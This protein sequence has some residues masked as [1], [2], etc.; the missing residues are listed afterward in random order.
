MNNKLKNVLDQVKEND[1]FIKLMEVT[2]TMKDNAEDLIRDLIQ[3]FKKNE[4]AEVDQISD[5][6]SE[7]D[8]VGT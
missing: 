7:R 5:I 6:H 3:R 2:S 1:N 4:E 8:Q